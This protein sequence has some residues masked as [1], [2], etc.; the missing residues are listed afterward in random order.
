M[1]GKY[2]HHYRDQCLTVGLTIPTCDAPYKEA[3]LYD[4]IIETADGRLDAVI[5]EL[6]KAFQPLGGWEKCNK[7][8][9]GVKC[10]DG[11]YMP[12]GNN[13]KHS[14]IFKKLPEPGRLLW[15]LFHLLCATA[16]DAFTDSQMVDCYFGHL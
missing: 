8:R 5:R 16:K 3:L 7:E 1:I 12:G 13:A 14:A 6:D 4:I 10:A 2:Y 9:F 15:D 11:A